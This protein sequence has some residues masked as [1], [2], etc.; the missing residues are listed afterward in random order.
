MAAN[1]LTLD[2]I[3]KQ[4]KLDYLRNW[5]KA[6]PEKHRDYDKKYRE[7]PH[8]IEVVKLWREQ[9]A[10][11]LRA[12]QARWRAANPMTAAEKERKTMM[13]D[14]PEF[15]MQ[16]LVTNARYRAKR[17]GL[18][19]DGLVHLLGTMP[20]HCACCKT[21]LDY[22]RGQGRSPLSAPSLDR[23]D[24]RRGYTK[25]NVRVVCLRCNQLK[26]NATLEQIEAVLAYMRS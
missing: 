25:D 2:E 7:S 16:L 24:T 8:G 17:K 21:T 6:H 12:T 5:I 20:I 23:F 18:E 3:R 15:R 22:A 9:N 10:E 14:R 4:R 13:R 26:N 11:R 1:E 19:F